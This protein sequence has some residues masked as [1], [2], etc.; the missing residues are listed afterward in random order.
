MRKTNWLLLALALMLSMFL[1]ACSGGSSSEEESSGEGSDTGETTEEGSDEEASGEQVLELVDSAEIPT[2]DP[3]M[4]TDAVAF[5]W[6][7]EVKEGLYRLGENGKIMPGIAKEH[8]VSDDA[9]TWTF[10]L[11]EDAVWSNGDKVTA[12]D[13]V[14]AWQRAVDPETKSEY[15]PYMLGGVIKNA[16][17]VN[18]G[19]VPVE[20]LGVTAKDDYTLVVELEKPTPYFESLTTFGTYLPLNKKF[21]EEQGENFALEVENMLYNGPFKMTEWNHGESWKVVKNEDYWDADAVT[22]EQINVTVVKETSTAVNL[23]ETGEIHR[24][25]LSAEYV[26][27]YAANEN[28]KVVERPTVFYLKMNQTQNKALAN[29]NVRKAIQHAID[30]QGLVDVILNNGSFVAN[31]LVPA[32]FVKHPETGED[33]RESSGELV[34]AGDKEAAKEYWAT[35][36]EELGTDTVEIE[37]LGDDTETAGKSS[38]YFKN[39]LEKTLEGLTVNVKQVPFKERIRLNQEMEYD[40]QVSGWGPDYIDPNTFMNLFITDGPNNNMGFSNEKY[41]SLLEKANNELALEP[42]KRWEA[43]VEAEQI[44]IE[45]EAAISPLY[46]RS[47]TYLWSPEM[48]G[49]IANPAGPDFEYK[50]ASLKQ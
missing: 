1:A 20:E 9:L 41:D 46:Q 47:K 27:Q 50:W 14:Y 48:Q 7:A 21:V 25:G 40:L 30:K 44:L 38:A 13:F 23:Y 15:G 17:K 28:L 18:E 49:V 29:V 12:H 42:V 10:T 33:F 5:Q 36:L 26:D 31:G 22:L 39:Q 35:A 2:M 11:R 32:N 4:A 3:S 6:L 19:E 34:G 45:E 43:F 8:K 37:L 16:T 24:A